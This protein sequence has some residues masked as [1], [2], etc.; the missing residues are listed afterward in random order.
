[1]ILSFA[2]GLYQFS[3]NEISST[4]ALVCYCS[5]VATEHH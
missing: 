3:K 2:A 1:M 4:A 5:S